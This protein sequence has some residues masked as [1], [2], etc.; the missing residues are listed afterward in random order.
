MDAVPQH[1]ARRPRLPGHRRFGVAAILFLPGAPRRGRDWG[2]RKTTAEWHAVGALL[3][4]APTALCAGCPLCRL[5][6]CPLP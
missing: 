5:P 2:R 1:A 3:I 6:L 4:S